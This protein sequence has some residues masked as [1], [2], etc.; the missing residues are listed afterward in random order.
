LN[1]VS[2]NMEIMK[3]TKDESCQTFS[4]CVFYIFCEFQ[5]AGK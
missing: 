2:L 5:N 1:R 3:V 4:V